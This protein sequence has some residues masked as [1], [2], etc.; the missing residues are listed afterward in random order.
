MLPEEE[1]EVLGWFL[2]G[3]RGGKEEERRLLMDSIAVK[4]STSILV[5]AFEGLLF[6]AELHEQEFM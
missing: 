4:W 1:R 3:W 2:G 6:Q 5:S